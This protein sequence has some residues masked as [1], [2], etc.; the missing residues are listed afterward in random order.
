MSK[1]EIAANLINNNQTSIYTTKN[2]TTGTAS[3][4]ESRLFGYMKD[5]VIDEYQISFGSKVA[6]HKGVVFFKVINLNKSNINIY[7][8]K[9]DLNAKG[10]SIFNLFA[11]FFQIF[12]RDF[13]IFLYIFTP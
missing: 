9:K 6:I 2:L 4:R 12:E 13:F 11:N 10:Y 5:L 8:D 7:I 3:Y 1:G